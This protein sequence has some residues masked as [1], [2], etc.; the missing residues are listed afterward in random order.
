[1]TITTFL[2]DSLN[3]VIGTFSILGMVQILA[4]RK[5]VIYQSYDNLKTAK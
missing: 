3:V 1:M 4:G 5:S 2:K